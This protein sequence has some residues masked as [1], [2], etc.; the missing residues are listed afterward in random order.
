MVVLSTL[1]QVLFLGL[2]S[3]EG[4]PLNAAVFPPESAPNYFRLL[5]DGVKNWC[6]LLKG[7]LATY[8]L[9]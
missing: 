6:N 1:A 4:M 5:L 9:N 8:P 3:P 7:N 2:I